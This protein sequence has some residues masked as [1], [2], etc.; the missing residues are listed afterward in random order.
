[1]DL[2]QSQGGRTALHIACAH[3]DNHAVRQSRLNLY[4]NRLRSHFVVA[5]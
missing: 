1:M 4:E 2:S 3:T 5:A